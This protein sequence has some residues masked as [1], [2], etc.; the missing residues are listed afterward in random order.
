MNPVFQWR[1][2]LL[3]EQANQLSPAK[4]L[5]ILIADPSAL[6]GAD[7]KEA[8]QRCSL[9]ITRVVNFA[10]RADGAESITRQSL[11]APEGP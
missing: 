6:Q 4:G 9:A 8:E 5:E 1:A 3:A 2:R 11:F 7:G 10:K